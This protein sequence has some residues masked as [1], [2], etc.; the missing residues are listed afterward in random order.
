MA[1][2]RRL[3]YDKTT[4]DIL[5][6]RM[7]QGAITVPTVAEDYTQQPG[8]VGRSPEDTG[9]FEWLTPDTVV[10]DNF[11]RATSYTV[12]VTTAPPVILFDFT[13]PETDEEEAE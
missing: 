12:D 10:E 4:G 1:F 11:A 2:L 5:S 7:A 9:L 8:L 13:P 6:H 3:Y